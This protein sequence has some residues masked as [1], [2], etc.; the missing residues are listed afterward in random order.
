[1]T[2][3]KAAKVVIFGDQRSAQLAHYCLAHDSNWQVAAFTVDAAYR[4]SGTFDGLPIFDF[5]ALERHCP[6]SEYRLLIP[7][8]YQRINGIR[9]ARFEQAKARGYAFANY[10]S[11]RATVWPDLVL[12][13]NCMVHDGAIVQPFA[14]VGD[15]VIIRSG[16][17]LSHHCRIGSHAFIAPMVAMAG[18]VVVGEQAFVGTGAVLVDQVSIAPRSFIAAGTVVTRDT[19]ADGV[20]VGNPARRL[21]RLAIDMA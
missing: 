5:E 7:M 1:M 11:S 9:K 21:Q 2:I 4:T 14:S 10:V 17:H 20:Y 3:Q 18:S 8:A 19:E 16:A 15:N 12:G 13:D 6:P